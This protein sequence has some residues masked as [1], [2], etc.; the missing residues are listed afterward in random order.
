MNDIIGQKF[1]RLTVI[2]FSH[3]SKTSYFY[4]CHC[5]CGNDKTI[6][7]CN[8]KSGSSKSC[9]C[10]N[11]EIITQR[12]TTHGM[13]YHKIY[14]VYIRMIGRCY[15]SNHIQ[16][17]DWGGRGIT[18][19]DEWKNDRTKFF[20]WAFANGWKKGL[21][22]DRINNDGNY[23]PGNCR[24]ITPQENSLNRR[25]TAI[26]YYNGQYYNSHELAA[27]SDNIPA[28][29]ILRRVKWNKWSV[30]RAISQPIIKRKQLA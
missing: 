19:C 15:Y 30:E 24:F 1:G 22:L 13:H 21:Q 5:D 12:A 7:R 29:Y 16:F 20:A 27:M 4:L 11:K 18:V 9:G 28:D 3:K 25:N 23:E 6:V 2:E 8:L 10:L 26:F 17:K 14:K